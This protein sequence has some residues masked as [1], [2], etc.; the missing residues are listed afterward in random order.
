MR[1]FAEKGPFREALS[2]QQNKTIVEQETI[3]I[4]NKH[5]V[6]TQI[7]AEVP[8]LAARGKVLL[9]DWIIR[10]VLIWDRSQVL[11]LSAGLRLP[12]CCVRASWTQKHPKSCREDGAPACA[13]QSEHREP[14]RLKF[15]IFAESWELLPSGRWVVWWSGCFSTALQKCT[16]QPQIS[17]FPSLLSTITITASEEL[18][19]SFIW[20]L[21]HTLCQNYV[22]LNV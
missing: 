15:R 4:I 20:Y 14:L 1:Q 8:S 21:P 3:A 9:G 6:Q 2:K 7:S 18:E 11:K 13:Q 22:P 5:L 10:I 16:K 17:S 19:M 12:G